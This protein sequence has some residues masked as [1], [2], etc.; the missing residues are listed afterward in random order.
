[1]ATAIYKRKDAREFNMKKSDFR[2]FNAIIRVPKN[3]EYDLM[4][5]RVCGRYESW[6]NLTGKPYW[7]YQY[8]A[9]DQTGHGICTEHDVMS[10]LPDDYEGSK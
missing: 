3:G 8:R 2:M 10:F 9:L 7:T 1:M 5:V 4:R 6:S